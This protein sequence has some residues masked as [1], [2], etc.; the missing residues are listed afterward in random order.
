MDGR[1][2]WRALE[3]AVAAYAAP[4]RFTPIL[5]YEWTVRNQL[6]GHH[7]VYFRDAASRRRVPLQDAPVLDSLWTR[8]ARA[9]TTATT[10]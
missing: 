3:Q 2:E 8:S 10:C 6:G 1:L 4:G 9:P 5:G 7:N